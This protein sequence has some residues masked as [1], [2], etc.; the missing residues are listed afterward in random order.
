M[1]GG[2]AV[3]DAAGRIRAGG[4]PAFVARVAAVVCLGTGIGLLVIVFAMSQRRGEDE[5]EEPDESD[6]DYELDDERAWGVE[7]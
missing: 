6:D 1:A 5:A 7:V 3:P 4:G 2:R